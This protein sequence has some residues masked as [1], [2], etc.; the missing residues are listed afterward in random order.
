GLDEASAMTGARSV[1][2]RRAPMIGLVVGPTATA[3]LATTR[4]RRARA[5]A[6]AMA[7]ILVMTTAF[8]MTTA[9]MMRMPIA[10]TAAFGSLAGIG[11]MSVPMLTPTAA[12]LVPIA[13]IAAAT[14]ITMVAR[15]LL[16]MTTSLV[17]TMLV[18]R[19]WLD[20]VRGRHRA[21]PVDDRQFL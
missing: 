3:I 18:F 4:A 16:V 17:G 12:A 10:M 21:P 2:D 11:V 5:A 9:V 13:V 7:S 1:A 20:V 19:R 8:L 14:M 6:I 15:G